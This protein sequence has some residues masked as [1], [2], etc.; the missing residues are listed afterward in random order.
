MLDAKTGMIIWSMET[1]TLS[2][3]LVVLWLHDTTKKHH[4]C[5]ASGFALVGIGAILVALRGAIPDFLSI[6]FGNISALA[7]FSLWLAALLLLGNRR[8]EGWIAIPPLTWIA[9]MFVPPVHDS[10]AARVILYHVCAGIGYFMLAG[11]LLTSKEFI[12]KTRK[13]LAVALVVQAFVG[14]IAAS[15]VIPYNLVTGQVVPLTTPI[16]VAGAF[17]FIVLMMISVKMFMEDAER[18]LQRLAMTDHLTGTL[19]RRGLMQEFGTLKARLAGTSRHLGFILF[20]IDNF[21][22][23]NDEY[24]HQ[25][26]DEV[27]VKFC[28]QAGQITEGRGFLI[29]MG[30]EEFGCLVE[31]DDPSKVAIL[32]EAIRIRFSRLDIFADGKQFSATVSAGVFCQLA[33]DAVLDT[34]LTMSDRALYGAKKEGRNRTVVRDG[35]VNM[36]IPAND[37]DEDPCDNN[38]D[39]QVAALTRISHIANR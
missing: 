22:K 19:N 39:R 30:G 7:A 16:V 14:A 31:T 10:M 6:Q 36:V 29:R 28:A 9:F 17:G 38:A 33:T 23:I 34:M 1:L 25:C 27:L 37:R 2:G 20:D 18:R 13:L 35:S 8:I 12:S 26:G 15:L 24:G 3:V 5:F 32:A 4:L 11:V 21:K